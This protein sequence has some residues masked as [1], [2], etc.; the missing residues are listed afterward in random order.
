MNIS[1]VAYAVGFT[2]VAHFSNAFKEFYG[3]P[4]SAFM[5]VHLNRRPKN[6]IKIS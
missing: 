1:E 6:E 4:P 2:S 5:E 3:E